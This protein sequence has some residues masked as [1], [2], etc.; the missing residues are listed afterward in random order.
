MSMV[1]PSIHKVIGLIPSPDKQRVWGG[2][3]D[4]ENHKHVDLPFSLTL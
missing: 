3:T 1:E 2:K 4:I